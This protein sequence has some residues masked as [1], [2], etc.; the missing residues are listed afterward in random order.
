MNYLPTTIRGCP[1]MSK[2]MQLRM[3][4]TMGRRQ[5]NGPWS[6]RTMAMHLNAYIDTHTHNWQRPYPPTT[7]DIHGHPKVRD[8]LKAIEPWGLGHHES[9]S[10]STGTTATNYVC[11]CIYICVCACAHSDASLLF[12][13]SMVVFSFIFCLYL[14][15]SDILGCIV[16]GMNGQPCMTTGRQFIEGKNGYIR[17]DCVEM[18]MAVCDSNR[19]EYFRKILVIKSY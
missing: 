9:Q 1:F 14:I 17:N 16:S 3:P 13:Y 19:G 4:N 18:A 12:F 11:L 10:P 15:A 8:A 5:K 7:T 2:T 6:R